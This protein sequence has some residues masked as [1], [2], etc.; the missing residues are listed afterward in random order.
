MKKSQKVERVKSKISPQRP[1]HERFNIEV[2]I[3]EARRHFV[4]RVY[5]LIFEGL[6]GAFFRGASLGSDITK[7]AALRLVAT[8]LGEKLE[9]LKS[10]D[11]YIREDFHRCLQAIEASYDALETDEHRSQLDVIINWILQESEVDLGI[12]WRNGKFTRSGAKLLDQ[13]LVNEPLRWLSDPRYK[14]VYAP[15]AKGLTHFLE[16]T[17]RPEL[18]SDVITDMYE[19]L[20]AL[21]KIVTKRPAK[22]LSANAELFIKSINAAEPY[23]RML[24]EYIDYANEFRH[25]AEEGKE[26]PKLSTTEVEAFVYLTGLFIRLAIRET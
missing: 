6:F 9:L 16:A 25:A 26:R 12:E 5:N 18:L 1:F 2:G 8:A 23:K 7:G 17:K 24:K 20:E 11:Y 19:A 3:D 13:E 14:D 21:A 4:N 22:D 15:F 10:F